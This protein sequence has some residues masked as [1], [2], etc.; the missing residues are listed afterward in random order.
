MDAMEVKT[1]VLALGAAA[2]ALLSRWLGGWD[3]VM[4][5]LVAV[6][7]ADYVT[8]VLLALVWQRSPKSA[9]GG[10]DSRA[11]FKGLCKK[12][13]ILLVIWLAVHLDQA[14]ETNYIRTAVILFFTGNEGLSLLENLGL[15]G[16]PLPPV[17]KK[18][19]EALRDKDKDP[20]TK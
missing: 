8:G 16:V 9:A 2:G 6:M 11:G 19:L 4:R 13:G 12:G 15:M 20:S 14:M 5:M 17:L 1:G 10:L 3:A 7:A 18:S